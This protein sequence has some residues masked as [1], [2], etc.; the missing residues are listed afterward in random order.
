MDELEQIFGIIAEL[1]GESSVPKNVL[2]KLEE[3][4]A[5]L[6]EEGEDLGIKVDQ[7]LQII[8]EI[9]EDNNLQPFVRTKL[10]N[11]SSL[12]EGL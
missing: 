12:L 11:I 7:A 1:R 2:N 3:L 9:S 10:W 5:L 8:E 6:R 4:E